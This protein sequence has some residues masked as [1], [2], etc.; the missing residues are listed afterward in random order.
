MSLDCVIYCAFYSILFS[1]AVFFR[2]RCSYTE[3]ITVRS[4]KVNIA[5]SGYVRYTPKETVN[6]IKQILVEYQGI[7]FVLLRSHH[8]VQNECIGCSS[9]SSDYYYSTLK[10]ETQTTCWRR[11]HTTSGCLLGAVHRS[12]C[13]WN[14]RLFKGGVQFCHLDLILTSII[15]LFFVYC[16]LSDC[17][18]ILHSPTRTNVVN[19]NVVS[20]AIHI[21]LLLITFITTNF[22]HF[23]PF[24]VRL[25]PAFIFSHQLKQL[26]NKATQM[27][28]YKVVAFQDYSAYQSVNK[29]LRTGAH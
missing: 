22:R 26:S 23:R 19:T 1:G 29:K 15:D 10:I 8:R 3:P 18:T 21:S 28:K 2:S 25:V 11:R 4:M 17:F 5:K 13:R 20:V 7:L 27:I 12:C 9:H 14:S 16:L 6:K 24:H